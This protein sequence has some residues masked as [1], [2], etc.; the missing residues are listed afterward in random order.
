MVVRIAFDLGGSP[1][2][3]TSHI[4]TIGAG[5]EVFPSAK[6]A[7]EIPCSRKVSV[8][9]SQLLK[10]ST[11][12]WRSRGS[13]APVSVFRYAHVSVSHLD[14]KAWDNRCKPGRDRWRSCDASS[15]TA[16]ASSRN[17]TS[18]SQRTKL[19][20]ATGKNWS[21]LERTGSK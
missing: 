1:L 11:S 12:V 13:E 19:L 7:F 18:W 10:A 20:L 3:E 8:R 16:N 17:S 5:G 6:L 14:R 2:F 4:R 9:E 21:L 15:L